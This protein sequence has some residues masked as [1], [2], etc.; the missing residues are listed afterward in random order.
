MCTHG[1]TLLTGLTDSVAQ[2]PLQFLKD[3]LQNTTENMDEASAATPLMHLY[4][5]CLKLREDML[6]VRM[7]VSGEIDHGTAEPEV[8]CSRANII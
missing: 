3:N 8:Y 2:C 7:A 5:G 6:D 1:D 4:D